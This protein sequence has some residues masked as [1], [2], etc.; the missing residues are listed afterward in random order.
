MARRKHSLLALVLC[1]L[2]V[3]SVLCGCNTVPTQNGG[4]NKPTESDGNKKED[5]TAIYYKLTVQ[6]PDGYIIE[7]LQEQYKAGE[8]VFV[9]TEQIPDTAV[10]A[11]LDGV[12][13]G[14]GASTRIKVD[15]EFQSCRKYYF[16]M[17]SH[18][19]VLS[20]Q[21]PEGLTED[22]IMLNESTQTE[23]KTAFYNVYKDKHPNLPFDH[24]SLRC[25][26]AFDGV[27]VIF[28]DG[29]WACMDL[30]TSEVIAGIIFTYPDS[31]H[32]TVYCDGEC[33]TLSEAYENG[34]LSYDD[35]LTTHDT[36]KACNGS[37]FA[38]D[39]IWPQEIEK[40]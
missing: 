31:L 28:E 39:E 20:F 7:D 34:I 11:Y 6:D 18:D 5:N 3:V 38:K 37:T 22:G 21:I 27:Y 36:Y 23:I 24:L 4:D 1:F 40:P 12:F 35:L 32:M 15:S 30:V 10:G 25:Y 16:I 26:G 9:T 19:A 29:V 33:S 13:F 17:P 2:L 14:L 8:G